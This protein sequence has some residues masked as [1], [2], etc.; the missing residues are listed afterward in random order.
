MV[1][2]RWFR[3]LNKF[4]IKF[5]TL[6]HLLKIASDH[7]SYL[8]KLVIDLLNIQSIYISLIRK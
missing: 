8:V 4:G 3:I 6:I 7:I 5:K 1:C 2:K